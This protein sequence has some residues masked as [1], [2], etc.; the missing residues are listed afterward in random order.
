MPNFDDGV[1]EHGALIP[2]APLLLACQG[3]DEGVQQ[4]QQI[5]LFTPDGGEHELQQI[6]RE[7]SESEYG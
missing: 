1:T 5:F 7:Y 2:G 3:H 6:T 4:L